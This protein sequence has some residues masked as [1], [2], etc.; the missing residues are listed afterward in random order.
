MNR[1]LQPLRQTIIPA[2]LNSYSIIFFFNNKLLAIVLMGITFFNVYAGASGLLAV[3]VAV[4]VGHTMGLNK[5]Q[6]KQGLFS[7]NALLTGVGMG[8]FFDP[9]WVSLSLLLIASML[10]LILSVTL[11]GWLGKYGLPFLSIP[12]VFTFWFI[13][14]PSSQFENLGLTARNIYWMNEV[15]AIGGE[16]M[17]KLYQ[18]ID[19]FPLYEMVD[20]YLRSLSSIF[21]QDNIIAGFLISITILI[22]SRITF[23]LTI[24][25][26]ISAYFFARFTGSEA[27]SIN[28]Y[29]IGANYMMVAIAV[30]SFF[31]I[32]SF[33]S[34]LWS[35]L[36][37]PLTSLILLFM[38]QLL[39]TVQ[40]PVFSLPFSMVVISFIYFLMLRATPSK[41]KLT[42]IQH[43]SP[44]TNLYLFKNNNERIANYIYF[45][46]HLPFWG[47]WR[48]SQGH[49]GEH[50]HK[51]EWRDAL[52]FMI[53][54][55]ESKTY[56]SNGLL[57][58]DYYCYNKPIVA[59]AD[60]IVELITDGID[61][62]E[63]GKVNL[64]ENWGNSIVIR[65]LPGLYTQLSHIRKGSFKVKAGDFV[66]QGDILALC[67]NSGRSPEPHLHFQMQVSPL[68]GAKTIDYPISYYFENGVLNQFTT[69]IENSDVYGV[70]P[71][72]LERNA[73]NIYPNSTL[74]FSYSD[75]KESDKVAQWDSYTDGYNNRYLHCKETDSTAY[76]VI[77][78]S[79]FY[80]T[81]FYG[82]RKS[83][84]YYFYLTAYKVFLGEY[85]TIKVKEAM[86]LSVLE[87]SKFFVWL[88]DFIAPFHTFI[89]VSHTVASKSDSD[90]FSA[91]SVS[92][93]TKTE[94]ELFG[95]STTIANGSIHLKNNRIESFSYVGD[96]T[97]IQATCI[98][99]LS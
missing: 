12:F 1:A 35:I 8:T 21:F 9:S 25:G 57:C 79:M 59:P 16:S 19:T 33:Y 47:K 92:L 45:P 3:V 18:Q 87:K 89:Y 43:Y 41:L 74:K 4:V 39:G 24:I 48:V 78:G 23:S 81:A 62:N 90:P 83:L 65:H 94:I 76:Y 84:L 13:V 86:P 98:S 75:G 53:Y 15:Y 68:L 85:D 49:D 96:K 38:N 66:K 69:P 71:N 20:I 56:Q 93:R 67:G 60:G 55:D 72:T 17:L 5:I 6:L 50:T 26:F 77:D 30:G 63:I 36:L 22:C 32:P 51:G 46:I 2:I 91:E 52:D 70:V 61:D 37:V 99:G 14:L 80:F 28:Y 7:F 73:F 31:L 34:Y 11:S 27:A 58:E 82:N 42:P 40:L 88:Q 29:N 10:T 44:E 95:K 64:T 54:D 97:N